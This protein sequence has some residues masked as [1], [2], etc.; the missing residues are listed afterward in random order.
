[1]NK[2]EARERA[3]KLRKEIDRLRYLYHVE[4]KLEISEAALDSLKHEL[5]N[6][7]R[8]Y[9]D[10]ITADSPTQ[11]VSGKAVAG[12][13]K[14]RHDIPMLSLEDAFSFGEV[15]E[16]ETRIRKLRPHATFEWYTDPKMDGLAVSLV[17]RE[18]ALEVGATRGDGRVGEDVTHN[19]RTIDAI[20]L[21]LREPTVSEIEAFLR[22]HRGH[23]DANK[24]R[25]MFMYRRGRLEFRGE[26]YMTKRQLEKLNAAY[27]KQGKPA[28]ANP[29]NAAAGSIRQLDPNIAEER[30]LTF[31]GYGFFGDHGLRTNEQRH[32]AMKLLG[33]PVNAHAKLCK[34]VEHV[35]AMHEHMHKIRDSLPYWIDGVVVSVNDDTLA[36]SL[37]VVGKAPRGMIAWKF[38]AEQGTTVVRDI[39]VSVGRTGV[40]TPVAVMDPVQLV[41]TTVT[42]ASLHNQDEIERLGLKKGDTVIVEKAGDVIPKVIEVLKKL[43]TGHETSFHMPKRCPVCGTAVRREEGKVAI[44]CPNRKCPAR[45]GGG[46]RYFVGKS[47]VDIHG[48]GEKIINQLLDEGFVNE[49]ADVYKLTVDDLKQLE[50][51]AD[52]SANKLYAEIQKHR[53]IPL[54]RFLNAL[55]IPGVGEET[56][57]DLAKHF[58]SFAAFRNATVDE[59]R[60]VDGVGDVVAADIRE[61]LD[62]P[63]EDRMLDRLL[64]EVHV[65]QAA[66]PNAGGKLEGTTWVFTGGLETMTR[67][68]AKEIVRDLGADVSESVSKNTTYVVA[69]TDP[70][71]KYDKAK[72]FGVEILTE[73]EFLK[74]VGKGRE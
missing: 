5:L 13:K 24:A 54:D 56:S 26:V 64:K 2:T 73:R 49:P 28:L 11:R 69:G 42:H 8:E 51:F 12:F 31:M 41:G 10:L 23:C 43:R 30:G 20:P 33:L 52:V 71:S 22:R 60:A 21:E 4:N 58:R 66:A 19:V 35:Q 17:Y 29:R 50:G 36:S 3:Q 67:E 7:E 46:L 72:K 40:L 15:Q 1:M 27:K 57:L 38:Q 37:G 68:E 25:A 9:P 53:R 16:W 48:L 63:A 6:I 70:G 34:T 74:K 45:R 18:G 32:E 44:V 61:F 55:G 47:A 59:L 14:V 62:D 65:E 39:A